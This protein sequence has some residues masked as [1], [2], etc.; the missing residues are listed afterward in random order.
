MHRNLRHQTVY[1]GRRELGAE[2]LPGMAERIE[3]YR[4][5]AQQLRL[6]AQRSRFP[7][8]GEQLRRLAASFEALADR[9]AAW[10]QKAEK[11]RPA[12]APV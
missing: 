4:R 12:S 6:L 2:G 7:D 5:T 11:T 3:E 10:E 8:A 9:V 1:Q